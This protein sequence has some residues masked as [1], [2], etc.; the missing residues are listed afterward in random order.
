[1]QVSQQI[2]DFQT[3]LVAMRFEYVWE[4]HEFLCVSL[5][6][7]VVAIDLQWMTVVNKGMNEIRRLH[8]EKKRWRQAVH[9]SYSN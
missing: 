9:A 1:M 6:H 3:V 5:K 4:F 8:E 7:Q 2:T